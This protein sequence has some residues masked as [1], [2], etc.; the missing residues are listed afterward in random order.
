MGEYHKKHSNSGASSALYLP[1]FMSALFAFVSSSYETAPPQSVIRF[2]GNDMSGS[3]ADGT[4][5]ATIAD[6]PLTGSSAGD[7]WWGDESYI[8]LE[9]VDQYPGGGRWQCKVTLDTNGY[10]MY[11]QMSVIE[12]WDAGVGISY[13]NAD[14][15]STVSPI[16]A[17]TSS[18]GSQW[19]D[20]N[21]P[22][23][24]AQWMFSTAN[25]DT[26]NNGA[27][28]Y[29]YFMWHIY[30]PTATEESKFLES[31]YVGGYI[32]VDVISDTRPACLLLRVPDARDYST[33]W[34]DDTTGNRTNCRGSTSPDYD[35]A[36]KDLENAGYACIQNHYAGLG[37]SSGVYM[38]DINGQWVNT[39]IYLISIN[40]AAIKGHF[41][42]YTFLAGGQER[43]DGIQDYA[44][45]YVVINNMLFRWNP[46]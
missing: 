46:S 10:D 12:S 18:I 15:D 37:V 35:Q 36:E 3:V 8:V 31:G 9:S 39:P 20:S 24:N 30:E 7:G 45:K 27:N 1:N 22:N 41:G 28:S 19:N 43:N 2:A 32:P 16:T 4:T 34:G 26:Y 40:A 42:Q 11:A 33:R 17:N 14:F 25:M 29:S 13:G 5:F 44:Q 38:K 6:N 23:A 21:A